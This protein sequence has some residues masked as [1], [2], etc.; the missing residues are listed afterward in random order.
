M[1]DLERIKEINQ[2]IKK[3]LGQWRDVCLMAD[4]DQ[5]AY[6][7]D[8]DEYDVLSVTFL[9]MHVCSNIGIK[10]QI[11]R[12]KEAV[13]C[14]EKIRELVKSM[15]GYDTHEVSKLLER[16]ENEGRSN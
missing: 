8:Y 14:G 9:F 11:I 13:E 15:T 7:L 4:A 2:H 12:E 10:K 5:W 16:N 1:N 3:G 6:M